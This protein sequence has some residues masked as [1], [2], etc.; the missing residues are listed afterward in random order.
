[1]A[2]FPVFP[3]W[4]F[5][6][7]GLVL[8]LGVVAVVG[9]KMEGLQQDL[10]QAQAEVQAL[11]AQLSICSGNLKTCKAGGGGVVSQNLGQASFNNSKLARHFLLRLAD[12]NS[13]YYPG[14]E[15]GGPGYYFWQNPKGF[16]GVQCDE[17]G[18]SWCCKEGPWNHKDMNLVGVYRTC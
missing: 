10:G 13:F 14:A 1:M 5:F 11:H 17:A 2:S 16:F 7:G 6:A 8:V 18:P 3:G 4:L 15:G 12:F 9:V